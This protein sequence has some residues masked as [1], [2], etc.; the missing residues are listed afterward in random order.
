L[1]GAFRHFCSA[2]IRNQ[3]TFPEYH[4]RTLNQ[5]PQLA[6]RV[7]D[8]DQFASHFRPMAVHDLPRDLAHVACRA[9]SFILMRFVMLVLAVARAGF[10]A[11]E[12]R[13]R[14]G[15]RTATG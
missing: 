6:D 4:S 13:M 8:S 5:H 2:A 9:A 1:P 14:P 15:C 10:A 7:I 3:P 12:V 11:S